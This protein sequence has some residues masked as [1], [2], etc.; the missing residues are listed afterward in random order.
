MARPGTKRGILFTICFLFDPL[1]F[2]AT[3]ALAA[4][5]LLQ[6]LCKANK[7]WD[8]PLSGDFLSK[9][10]AWNTDL[11]LTKS[12]YRSHFLPDGEPLQ[13][14]LQFHVFSD[15]SEVGYGV[16]SY[17]RNEYIGKDRKA[18]VKCVSIPRLELQSAV[19]AA[20]M[21]ELL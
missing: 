15:A 20:Q 13:C 12:I 6:D 18:P 16:S 10:S 9:G 3:V 14:K 5:R 7:G 4:R 21:Y 11:L 2:A 8:E 19:L 17:F 1:V